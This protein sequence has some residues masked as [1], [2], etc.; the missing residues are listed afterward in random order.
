LAAPRP[1]AQLGNQVLDA[2]TIHAEQAAVVNLNDQIPIR[3]AQRSVSEIQTDIARDRQAI[4]DDT[5]LEGAA[6]KAHQEA[7]GRLVADGRSL[8]IA[9]DSLNAAR[10]QV[11]GD[12][13]RIRA[14][15][16][17]TY[18]GKFTN[19][20]PSGSPTP[21]ADQLAAIDVAEVQ[22]VAGIIDR[23]LRTD[24]SFEAGATRLR[25]QLGGAV[26]ADQNDLSAT[27]QQLTSAEDRLLADNRA[28][29]S[30]ETGLPVA[31]AQ[32]AGA[33]A[34]LTADLASVAGPVG[35]QAGSVSLLGGSALTAA[36]MAAWYHW[37]GYADV[38]SAPIEQLA[39]WYIQAGNQLGVRGDVA[40]AQSILETG[41]YSSPDAVDL[42]NYAGIGHCDSCAS[43]WQF[44]S[45]ND[46]VIGHIQLLRIFATTALP[47]PGS[48]H[49]VLPSLT[50]SSQREAGCCPSVESLTGVWATDPTYGTQILG[51]YQ[52]MLGYALA[53]R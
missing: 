50:I 24:V 16:L 1:Q 14:L 41:G 29:A 31:S 53:Q 47:P 43:G 36:Q 35:A 7:S 6:A 13:A 39:A 2:A 8:A 32:L 27:A 52:Q 9:V 18:T 21:E 23:R 20:Q 45:P 22:V 12:R 48:P 49:P 5:S 37:T 15:A 11:E 38:T 42:N 28:L 4:A 33:Q 26:A 34:T 46:G 40:F 44:P 10:G 19:P 17:G 3:A 30:A 25:D 51:I